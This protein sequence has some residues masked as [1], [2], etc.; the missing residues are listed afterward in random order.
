MK[1]C[2]S[3]SAVI[4][5]SLSLLSGCG[6]SGQTNTDKTANNDTAKASVTQNEDPEESEIT[7]D[8]KETKDTDK[9][10][11]VGMFSES[12]QL[13]DGSTA[14][15]DG[16]T[17]KIVSDEDGEEFTVFY[18][19]ENDTLTMYAEVECG[20]EET[21]NA[22]SNMFSAQSEEDFVYDVHTEGTKV[23][24]K[25]DDQYIESFSIYGTAQQIYEALE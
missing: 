2:L 10:D 15:L 23:C 4:C 3:I 9:P 6:G 19:F 7:K 21:A 17:L 5:I 13:S 16:N 20:D 22:V 12:K 24:M 11:D 14:Y 8:T 1:K 25:Y 18:V